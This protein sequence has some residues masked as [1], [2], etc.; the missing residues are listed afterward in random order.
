MLRQPTTTERAHEEM[1]IAT[2]TPEQLIRRASKITRE[3]KMAN[4]LLALK[5]WKFRKVSKQVRGIALQRFG[6]VPA[7]R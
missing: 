5:E 2:M 6:Y 3:Q 1:R 4:F 7:V